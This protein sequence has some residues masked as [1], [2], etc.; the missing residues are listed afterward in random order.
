MLLPLDSYSEET[1]LLCFWMAIWIKKCLRN[2]NL[3]LVQ[4]PA[5]SFRVDVVLDQKNNYHLLEYTAHWVCLC[6][7]HAG[8]GRNRFPSSPLSLCWHSNTRFFVNAGQKWEFRLP[9]RP[10]GLHCSIHGWVGVLH[11]CTTLGFHWHHR[12]VPH[13]QLVVVGVLAC[14]LMSLVFIPA[15]KSNTSLVSGKDGTS[16]TLCGL[17]VTMGPGVV[18]IPSRMKFS[19][20]YSPFS[21]T[22]FVWRGG[23][24][25][26]L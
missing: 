8:K 17:H 25:H 5:L 1:C 26:P 24:G 3:V 4:P 10:L 21:D 11:Y 6:W 16:G 12:W 23:W 9:A 18:A 2:S 15:G 7:P 14:H 22:T 19:V 20:P 13:W